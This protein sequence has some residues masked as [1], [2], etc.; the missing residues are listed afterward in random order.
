MDERTTFRI[1]LIFI[2]HFAIGCNGPAGVGQDQGNSDVVSLPESSVSGVAD[3]DI[4]SLSDSSITIVFSYAAIAC[5]CPQWFETKHAN[6]KFQEGVERFYLEP[7]NN[8]LVNANS[9]WDGVHLPLTVKVTGKFS[10]EK[11]TAKTYRTKGVPEN[12]RIFWYDSITVV[13]PV[14]T[15]N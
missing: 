6:V 2:L 4:H 11:E 8:K 9:L 13:S 14:L 12:A 15:S 1:S 5:R 7:I 10:K 3:T